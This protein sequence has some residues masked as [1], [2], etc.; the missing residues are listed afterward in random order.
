VGVGLGIAVLIMLSVNLLNSCGVWVTL[1]LVSV[2]AAS[3]LVLWIRDSV[4]YPA[5]SFDNEDDGEG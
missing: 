2:I 3:A 4:K 5:T 1:L